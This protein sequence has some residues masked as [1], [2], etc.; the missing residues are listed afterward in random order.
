MNPR[1]LL[2]TTAAI[3]VFGL[4]SI[5]QSQ[6]DRKSPEADNPKRPA[7]AGQRQRQDQQQPQNQPSAR[8]RGQRPTDLRRQYR[9]QARNPQ[10][11]PDARGRNGYTAP[12]RQGYQTHNQPRRSEWRAEQQRVWPRYRAQRWNTQHRTWVQRGGYRGY[13]V[14]H[15]Q[16]NRYFGRP[17]R[18]HLSSYQVRIFGGYPRFYSN[19]Y[20]I[21][22]LDPV[23]EYWGNDWYD[24]D[25]V[26]VV[27]SDGGYYLM[28]EAYPR[29]QIS[30][31]FRL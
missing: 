31:S 2:S 9:P 14:A 3:L 18:F 11:R 22:I 1:A 4:A 28:N 6:P 8:D 23:P 17:H 12:H 25:Y 27:E 7:R 30:I 19:G 13:R 21:T 10:Q 24:T 29:N 15:P 26:T 5:A 16:F 20:W